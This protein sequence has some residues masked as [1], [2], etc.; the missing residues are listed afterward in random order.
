MER[1]SFDPFSFVIL[2][3]ILTN[4]ISS[5]RAVSSIRLYNRRCWPEHK[6]LYN[7][8]GLPSKKLLNILPSSCKYRVILV[9]RYIFIYLSSPMF[10]NCQTPIQRKL[11]DVVPVQAVV[12]KHP[13]SPMSMSH[14]HKFNNLANLNRSEGEF[15]ALIP[16]CP[17]G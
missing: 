3:R 15:L 9:L 17:Q 2:C 14:Y 16:Q 8:G 12:Y 13:A 5:L 1:S 11:C 4:P 10:R 6:A 7:Y